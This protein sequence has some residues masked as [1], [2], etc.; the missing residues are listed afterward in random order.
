MRAKRFYL[1]FIREP[2]Y[3]KYCMFFITI[4]KTP[5]TSITLTNVLSFSKILA[6]EIVNK[7]ESS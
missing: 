6:Q 4:S 7:Y 2:S 1:S 3:L 5:L